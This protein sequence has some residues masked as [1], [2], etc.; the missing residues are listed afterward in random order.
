MYKLLKYSLFSVLA[1]FVLSCSS[2]PSVPPLNPL[3]FEDYQAYHALFMG[4][5]DQGSEESGSYRSFAFSN[6]E[7]DNGIGIYGFYTDNIGHNTSP[8]FYKTSDFQILI[9]FVDSNFVD[10]AD[11][12]FTND[13]NTLR[14]TNWYSGLP[15]D[16]LHRPLGEVGSGIISVAIPTGVESI[17]DGIFKNWISSQTTSKATLTRRPPTV[18]GVKAGGIIAKH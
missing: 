13:G 3:N 16:I 5:W 11:Y 1:L 10:R 12:T 2:S 17:S 15:D 9:Y 14:L 6:D 7:Y 4:A 8:F 18:H